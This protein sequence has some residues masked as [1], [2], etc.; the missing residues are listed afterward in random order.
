MQGTYA[1]GSGSR[2]SSPSEKKV[3]FMIEKSSQSIP[4]RLFSMKHNF[5]VRYIGFCGNS[6]E[7]FFLFHNFRAQYLVILW[8]KKQKKKT[9]KKSDLNQ[10]T[11]LANPSHYPGQP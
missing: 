3:V 9:Y 11:M 1:R 4:K 8:V 2:K 7:L 10:K 5:R 6:L